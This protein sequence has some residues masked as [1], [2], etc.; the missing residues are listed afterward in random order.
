MLGVNSIVAEIGKRPRPEVPS[1]LEALYA[2]K[3]YDV[4]LVAALV[5]IAAE[6]P[7][8]QMLGILNSI[9]RNYQPLAA[10]V[11]KRGDDIH[12]A[13]A[14]AR[15]RYEP[16]A[17]APRIDD[18]LFEAAW[19][20][21][22]GVDFVIGGKAVDA[23][24]WGALHDTFPV[25]GTTGPTFHVEMTRPPEQSGA[26]TRAFLQLYSLDPGTAT[27]RWARYDDK[28]QRGNVEAVLPI[29]A[30]PNVLP[31]AIPANAGSP[32]VRLEITVTGPAPGRFG[33]RELIVCPD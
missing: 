3:S 19:E 17:P 14:S 15:K 13:F 21:M 27:I 16:G 4:T 5:T 12:R 18:S 2:R 9:E 30:G 24:E 11:L 6:L 23:G 26:K 7:S 31:F 28:L 1:L 33:L 22:P 8:R 20:I 25:R 10:D 29:A 32:T